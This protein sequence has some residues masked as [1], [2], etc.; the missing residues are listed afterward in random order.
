MNAPDR[1]G[2]RS[3]GSPATK[4]RFSRWGWFNSL[5]SPPATIVPVRSLMITFAVVAGS[6]S[7]S[8]RRATSSTDLP[9][10]ATGA[11]TVMVPPSS[12]VAP[13][14]TRAP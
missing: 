6:T 12:A 13:D 9:L 7:M 4:L 2:V 1:A 5:T 11:R 10:S 14:G 8:L 3:S